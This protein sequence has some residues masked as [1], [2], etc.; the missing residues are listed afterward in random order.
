MKIIVT[1]IATNLVTNSFLSL[2]C[3]FIEAE[4][5]SQVFSKL[6]VWKREIV[7]LLVYNESH[8]TSKVCQIQ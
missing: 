7:L 3:P 2:F 4:N 6:A 8:S 5:K 1:T